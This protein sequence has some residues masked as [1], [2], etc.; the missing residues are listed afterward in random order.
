MVNCKIELE[1]NQ[2]AVYYA[3]ELLKGGFCSQ[4]FI[5]VAD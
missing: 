1:N 3:G 4:F 5:K 2:R